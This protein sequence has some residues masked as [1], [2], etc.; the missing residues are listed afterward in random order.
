[1]IEARIALYDNS[2]R[3]TLTVTD[4]ADDHTHDEGHQSHNR[5]YNHSEM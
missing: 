4:A 3:S 5:P 1:M 2:G